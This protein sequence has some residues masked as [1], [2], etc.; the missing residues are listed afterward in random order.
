MSE[1]SATQTL[2]SNLKRQMQGIHVQR[3]EDKLTQGV[4]DMNVC[5]NGGEAWLEGKFLRRLPTRHDTLVRFGSKGERRLIM[6]RNWLNTRAKA[7]GL[8]FVWLRIED[9]D[10]FLFSGDNFDFLADGIRMGDLMGMS[11][12]TRRRYNNSISIVEDVRACLAS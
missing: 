5:W 8:C 6:Q 11:D 9:G 7:G 1:Q 2:I 3:L 4:P 10:W 12:A